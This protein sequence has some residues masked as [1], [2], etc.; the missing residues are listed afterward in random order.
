MKSST[1]KMMKDWAFAITV[2]FG[3]MVT[4]NMCNQTPSL[5]GEAPSFTRTTLD[6]DV[7][8]LQ[9]H[10]GTPVVL[11]FWAT[12]CGP[13]R[14]EIPALAKFHEEHPEIPL[15]GISLDT[16]LSESTLRSKSRQLGITYPVIYDQTNEL[17]RDYTVSSLPTTV[18]IDAEGHVSSFWQ[19]SISER[20]LIRL[21]DL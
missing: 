12:W 10:I 2:A 1:L 3:V 16:N 19:G 9:K 13:C 4:F 21:L 18:I 7:F 6:G 20:S 17:G 14:R 11:N 5:T 15:I 8:D